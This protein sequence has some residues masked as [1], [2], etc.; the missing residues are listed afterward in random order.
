MAKQKR[1]YRDGTVISSGKRSTAK[2]G[3]KG[4]KAKRNEKKVPKIKVVD[5]F[6]NREGMPE[7]MLTIHEIA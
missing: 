7:I 2:S 4:G 6:R 1:T 3:R 5:L